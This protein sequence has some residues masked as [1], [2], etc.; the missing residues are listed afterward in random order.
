MRIALMI[1][2]Q[3]DVSWSDWVALADAWDV[4]TSNRAYVTPLTDEDALA[5]CRRQVGAQF[6]APAVDALERLHRGGA[7]RADALERD[8]VTRL[9]SP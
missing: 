4:M 6:W 5:E 8:S 2:G 9:P 1:E 7:L 3:E